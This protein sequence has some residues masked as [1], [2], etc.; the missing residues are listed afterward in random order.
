[1]ATKTVKQEAARRVVK[2]LIAMRREALEDRKAT[3]GAQRHITIET[4][5]N[6]ALG[7]AKSQGLK[8]LPDRLPDYD[9]GKTD[10]I[11][12]RRHRTNRTAQIVKGLK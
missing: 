6:H 7:V 8:G 12:Y 5:Y 11:A 4:R 1:M 9:S 10:D 3:V 2:N